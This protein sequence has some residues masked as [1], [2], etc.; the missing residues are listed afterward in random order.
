MRIIVAVPLI[1]VIGFAGVALAASA[2]QA[3]DASALGVRVRLAAA[4]GAL[5]HELQRERAS[6][7]DLLTA[8]APGQQDA[9]ARQTARTDDAVAEF[10]AQRAA[11]R[12]VPAGTRAILA[13]VDR[14]L[15]G[16]SPLRTQVR[17]AA[18]APVSA[19]TFS[20]RIAVA[21]LLAYRESTA[22][23][24]PEARIADDIRA[25]AALSRVAEALGQEQVAVMRAV[26]AGQ[27][28]P[29]MQQDITASR[30]GFTEASLAFL[31][32]ARPSW[33][34][35][36]SQAG[37]G[38]E[39][40]ALQRLQDEVSRVQPGSRLRLNTTAWITATQAA[41]A[42]QY[43]VQ[44]RVDAEVLADV[45]A[46]HA[47][48][49]RRAYAE[50]GAMAVAL[51]LTL[52]VT[53]AV[54]RQ[55]TRRLRRLR[56]AAH[57]VAYTELPATVAELRRAGGP[58]VDPDAFAAASAPEPGGAVRD[59]IGEVGE[60]FNA[61]HRAAV[62]TAAEQAVMRANTADIFI[63][64]S[65]REQRLVD[66]VL[67][68][69]DRV[70]QD[71]TDPERL[72]RLYT[73][74][75]LATRMARINASLL[76]LGGV[77]VGRVRHRDV[78]LAEVL[79][80]ALS[81]IEHYTR[82]RL[83]IVDGD[84]AVAAEAVDEV[85]HLLAELMD[86]ATSYSPPDTEAWATARGLGDRVI[87]QIGDEGV[88]LPPQRLV[89]L[90]ELLAAPPDTDVAAVRAMG[91]V[92]VGQLAGRLGAGVEL[93]AGPKLGTIA[94]VTLPSALIRPT[95]L[96]LPVAG[97]APPEL[98][99]AP[100][101]VGRPELAGLPEPAFS[102]RVELPVAGRSPAGMPGATEP[103]GAGG[104]AGWAGATIPVRPVLTS[105]DGGN[106]RSPGRPVQWQRADAAG[107]DA[108]AGPDGTGYAG[109]SG[110][111]G[112]S[113]YAGASGYDAH[114][115]RGGAHAEPLAPRGARPGGRP[116]PS[117]PVPRQAGPDRSGDRTPAGHRAVDPRAVDPRAV[118]PRPADATQEL[119]IFQ[120]VNSWFRAGVD[121]AQWR[122]PADE[123]WRA[124]TEAATAEPP[125]TTATG[126]PVRVPQRHLV[127]GGVPGDRAA[128][129]LR[130]DPSRVAAA[131]SAY[132][133]G[134]AARRPVLV[135]AAAAA[136]PSAADSGAATSSAAGSSAAK[137]PMP[138]TASTDSGSTP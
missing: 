136:T 134:V 2:R 37:S 29:A 132:A 81:Q 52:A 57:T 60:A 44:R 85:V 49:R 31:A 66:A 126:L 99:G 131:M 78:P 27:L 43:D 89:Q 53:W 122:T 70:E 95:E 87:V 125:A 113:G 7:A 105:A 47:A 84:V 77:G 67:A 20:Y 116:L 83:G 112:T 55:I 73:L 68:Q 61:V 48:Q 62:R 42:R 104:P 24:V 12:G 93:R 35:W 58:P 25:A 19:M 22:Q 121:E 115:G 3:E 108:T 110:Y 129:S 119:P 102:G 71:E 118:D 138:A 80:A 97:H 17:T 41:A 30:T 45:E 15:D 8:G 21:D 28:T 101:L 123:G 88:G 79:Q 38:P 26:A 100:E 1:A 5:A 18:Q 50:G 9:F 36:W 59:E 54:A 98:A 124:A 10:R 137:G 11:L 106:G 51:L 13:R 86:N 64:L 74:D 14:A 117:R 33:R 120:Q 23:G 111:G 39:A 135:N 76:V 46:A 6:A 4:A 128:R 69:V 107:H 40:V 94:E 96:E 92:V 63:H 72:D 65:R 91:L 56:D 16:L 133:R 103:F 90:N 32:Q 34:A 109:T 114:P 82:V 75:H 130:R 127:P